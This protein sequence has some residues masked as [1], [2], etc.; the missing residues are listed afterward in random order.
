MAAL[1][2]VI[3]FVFALCNARGW[4]HVWGNDTWVDIGLIAVAVHLLLPTPLPWR[5]SS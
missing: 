3:A 4:M 5:R 2:A 1:V